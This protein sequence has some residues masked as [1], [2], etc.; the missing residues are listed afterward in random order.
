MMLSVATSSLA[1]VVVSDTTRLSLRDPKSSEP[2]LLNLL[3][4]TVRGQQ[5][6]NEP[7]IIASTGLQVGEQILVPGSSISNALKRL[8]RTGLYSDVL[9]IEGERTSEGIY[10]I[11]EVKEQPR[12]DSFEIRGIKKSARREV[13]ERIPLLTG[14]GITSASKAQAEN[15][16]K[17]YYS[18]K[19]HRNTIVKTQVQ[20]AD[21][22]LN[23][24]KLIFEIEPGDR[25]QIELINIDGNESFSDR[26]IRKK[27]KEVKQN[28]FY[29]LT[30]QVFKKDKYEE[31][32]TNLITF[33]QSKGY[34]DVE[35]LSDSV[36]VKKFGKK[37][38]LQI[39]LKIQ[40]GTKY[41]VRNINWD[42]NTIYTDERLTQSLGFK[43][44][45][46]FN[47]TMY[48]E[49]L[50]SNKENT[51]INALYNDI[52]YLFF[53]LER[54]VDVVGKDSVDLNFFII[55][56][57]IFNIGKV[58]IKG[59]TRTHDNVIRRELRTYPG[60]IYSRQAIIRSI[61][62]L[63][64]LSYFVPEK[65]DPNLVPDYEAKTVD[66]TYGLEETS[67]TDNFELSGG[68]GGR[69]IGMIL[70]ARVNFNNFS[71]QN[72]FNRDSYSILP[73]GDGQK[74]SLGIQV[75]G[76]GYQNYD[77]GFSEPW[78]NGKPTSVG[79][80]TSYSLYNTSTFN[81]ELFSSS[82]SLGRRLIWPD[83]YFQ[84][85]NSIVIQKY[86]VDDQEG[87]FF[88]ASGNTFLLIFRSILERNSLDNFIS[89]NSG[90]KFT[91][92][93]EVAPPLFTFSQYYKIKANFHYHIPIVGKL[94][95]SYGLEWGHLG[96][97]GTGERSQFQR[98]FMG[99]TPLQQRQ[100][101][102][103]DNIDLRGFPGGQGGS[104]SPYVNNQ[105]V[106][107][108]IYNKYS[109]EMRY[110]LVSTAQLQ[111]IP[112]VFAEAGNVYRTFSTYDP[113][114][115][116]RVSGFGT[117]IFLPILGLVDLSYGYRF[118]G[119]AGTSILPRKWEF[120]FNIGAPF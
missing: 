64:T 87:Q 118:D 65:M 44:G 10:L 11:I 93:G 8:Y 15:A 37:E 42:G 14:F 79:F 54:S 60:E 66:I 38:G 7:F 61:R 99:G 53:Q 27:M 112:Y 39:D 28:T 5:Y 102:T 35:I 2:E 106:G 74:L 3:G 70:S 90:S 73:T 75:T 96:W 97:L 32:K 17:R 45:D 30:R 4:I 105:P 62:Q 31:A 51:D 115:V 57:E 23:R 36:Y 116:K 43:K 85:S 82:V 98:F 63:Q 71:I 95:M 58:E 109:A 101:F 25:P 50:S 77:L 33:Y 67:G 16:I 29:R 6:T 83:D 92:Q 47:Q 94:V 26:L 100:S 120:L 76:R 55:E 104:I 12:L 107:G 59:N 81:Y 9:I 34:K 40:E 52:G 22:V 56:D 108:R 20:L 113:F 69:G 84:N 89:P 48:N 18:E 49:N 13:R 21:S 110:P 78:F 111:L 68:F 72:A 114:N 86:N 119:V 19:G 103:N 24:A 46:V 80:N 117:R 88:G 41:F 91:L 1:Q